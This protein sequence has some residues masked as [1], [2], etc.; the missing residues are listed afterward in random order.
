[1]QH[2]EEA[3]GEAV[4]TGAPRWFGAHLGKVLHIGG[5]LRMSGTYHS[6]STDGYQLSIAHLVDKDKYF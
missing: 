6:T 5:V 4:L 3:M 1:M 2:D